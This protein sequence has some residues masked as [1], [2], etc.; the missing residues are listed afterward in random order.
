MTEI[1][2]LV[3]LNNVGV[4]RRKHWCAV[5]KI[6]TNSFGR[7]T[8]IIHSNPKQYFI[9]F[10]DRKMQSFYDGDFDLISENNQFYS[11]PFLITDVSDVSE[12][13]VIKKE[14]INEKVTF[15]IVP[16]WYVPV[17][18]FVRYANEWWMKDTK[19][20]LLS[21]QG[22]NASF[23]N[24]DSLVIVRKDELNANQ[25]NKCLI[26]DDAFIVEE[27]ELKRNNPF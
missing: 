10:R 22:Y 13:K 21:V 24:D 16:F 18:L 5:S 23:P 25:H 7:I 12:I 19:H 3:R 1:N 11:N 8:N 15:C 26:F 20:K 4:R 2:K 17:K 9:L 6:T 14:K 27:F